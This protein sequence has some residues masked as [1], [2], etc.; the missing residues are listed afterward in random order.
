[1]LIFPGPVSWGSRIHQLHLFR[2]VRLPNKCRRYDTK[3]DHK[4]L[5]EV[6]YPFIAIT[7]RST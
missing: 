3:Y 5:G 1:M 6:E 4:A 7:P 2:G